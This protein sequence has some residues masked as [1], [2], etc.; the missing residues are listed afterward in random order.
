MIV[1]VENGSGASLLVFENEGRGVFSSPANYRISSS[2]IS[3]EL[4]KLDD[5]MFSDAVLLTGDGA[6][7]V[8]HGRE[9]RFGKES[10]KTAASRM[11]KINLPFAPQALALGD[12]VWDRAGKTEL[13]LLAED[14]TIQIVRRGTAD[15][16]PFSVQEAQAN[17]LQ[18]VAGISRGDVFKL[19]RWQPETSE[20]WTIADSANVAAPAVQRNI[21]AAPILM[22]ANLSGQNTDD[23]LFLDA[24]TR[25]IKIL[26]TQEIEKQNGE[27]ALFAGER[28]T[29]SLEA[30]NAPVAM[31]SMKLNIFAR[32]GLVI[33][34]DGKT[35]PTFVPAAPTATFT[36]TKTADTNDGACNADCSLREAITAANADAGAD[37]INIPAGAYTLTLANS[38]DVGTNNNDDNN[39]TG[40]LDINGDLTLVGTAGQATTFIQGGTSNANGID[41][42]FASNPFCTSVVNTSFTGLTVRYGRNTQPNGSADFSFTGG[43]LDWCNPGA[44]G[45]LTVTNSTFDNNSATT[46]PGGGIDLDTSST[47]SGSVSFATTT[48]FGY[49]RFADVAAGETYIISAKGKRFEFRQ[50]TQVLNVDEDVSDV[51]FIAVSN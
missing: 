39:A 6:V 45:T 10:A 42:V 33:L 16:R 18:A 8:L 35:E 34:Q 3:L 22:K 47:T 46:G 23:I 36:V 27:V 15:E 25:E 19:K 21:T 37:T 7:A 31:L 48:T 11:E 32:P 43:G 24:E 12:F 9:A 20:N 5:D 1:G 49:Y 17:R 29:Y 40:D 50:P 2:A 13:A 26:S 38:G 41:K 44:N 4:G 30:A 14:G 51:N 28:S